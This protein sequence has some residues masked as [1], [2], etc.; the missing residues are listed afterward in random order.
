MNKEELERLLR[1]RKLIE[2]MSVRI[3]EKEEL[4][5]LVLEKMASA[6]IRLKTELEEIRVPSLQSLKE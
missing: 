3:E 4:R 1:G 5:K 6:S 2:E